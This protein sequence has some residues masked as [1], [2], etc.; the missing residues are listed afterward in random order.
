MQTYTFA[1]FSCSLSMFKGQSYIQRVIVFETPKE[2][3]ERTLNYLSFNN[4][5]FHLSV[6]VIVSSKC[7]DLVINAFQIQKV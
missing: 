6:A 5:S 4:E 1:L 3:S 2:A 7:L